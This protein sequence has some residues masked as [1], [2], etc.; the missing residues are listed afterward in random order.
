MPTFRLTIRFI[1]A[2]FHG[3]ADSGAPEWPPS[4]LRAFQALVAAAAARWG[5]DRFE[6]QARPALEWLEAL[7]HPHVLAPVGWPAARP[8][9]LYVPNNA[10][11]LVAAGWARGNLDAS[12]ADHRTEKDVRP[13][14]LVNGD[15]VHFDWSLTP[16]QYEAGLA[17]REALRAMARSITHLGWGID[18]AVGTADFH[19]APPSAGDAERWRPVSTG[20]T[21]LRV[22]KEGTLAAL[23]ARHQKFVDRL[24][25]DGPNPVPPLSV[26]ATVGY[27][28]DADV[29][30]RPFA[31]FQLLTP[32]AERKWS[33][34]AQRTIEVAG[35]LRHATRLAAETVDKS[36]NWIDTFVLGHGEGKNGQAIGKESSRRFAYVPLPTVRPQGVVGLVNRVLIVEPAGGNGDDAAWARRMLAGKE[37]IDYKKQS[38]VALLSPTPAS[39][40]VIRQYTG[41]KGGAPVWS[42]V[43]PVVLPGYDDP[44]HLRRRLKDVTDSKAKRRL[45]ERLDARIG[46]LLRKAIIHAGFPAPLAQHAE[47]SW[48]LVGFRPGLDLATNYC[49][50]DHLRGEPRYHVRIH[51]KDASGAPVNVCGP[52]VLGVGRFYGLGLFIQ[53]Q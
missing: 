7:G 33:R 30:P 35:M 14:R 13:T 50:P 19:D 37:L 29:S 51:W 5:P 23:R 31:A 26:F 52:V 42:T 17:H 48:R 45:Y 2:A 40:W 47:L 3:R 18:Q 4:P 1:D 12:I 46:G 22:P 32:D 28:R 53:D 43:T 8:Y 41:D 24:T 49:S 34:D 10:A 16:P 39:D 21:P 15:A 27:R 11:D 25:P 20:G 9:R 44:D 6:E 36:Q 38:P